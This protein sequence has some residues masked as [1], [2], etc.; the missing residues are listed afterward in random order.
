MIGVL[1]IIVYVLGV[2]PLGVTVRWPVHIAAAATATATVVAI[3]AFSFRG[4]HRLLNY[5]RNGRHI[6]AMVQCGLLR[7]CLL[8]VV[9]DLLSAWRR[10]CWTGGQT[11]FSTWTSRYVC[12]YHHT[13]SDIIMA[14]SNNNSSSILETT[15]LSS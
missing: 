5:V 14:Q 6:H 8:V 12:R 4:I 11:N 3:V 1:V 9:V 15:P 2:V 7:R 10:E 13:T